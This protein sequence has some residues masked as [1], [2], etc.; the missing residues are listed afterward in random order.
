MRTQKPDCLNH[1][2]Q[3]L[4]CQLPGANP[5]CC[6]LWVHVLIELLVVPFTD[7]ESVCWW[8]FY[9][10]WLEIW[11]TGNTM[12]FREFCV[13]GVMQEV[14]VKL[15]Q[16]TNHPCERG[17]IGLLFVWPPAGSTQAYGLHLVTMFLIWTIS[18][19][20]C[21]RETPDTVQPLYEKKDKVSNVVTSQVYT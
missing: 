9:G 7:S 15:R 19:W 20:V 17:V 13:Q 16:I 3:T 8:R 2:L 1:T 6:L 5:V 4:T 10:G 18:C 12:R 21:E 11:E 14:S